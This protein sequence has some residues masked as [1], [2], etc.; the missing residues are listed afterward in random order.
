MH[1][2]TNLPRPVVCHFAHCDSHPRLVSVPDHTSG[3]P[4]GLS[5]WKYTVDI[6]CSRPR[7]NNV[8][9]DV[10]QVRVGQAPLYSQELLLPFG[11]PFHVAL[12]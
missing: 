8:F 9:N 5:F 7:G 3:V 6:A 10:Q 1:A 4:T 2:S 11:R 12:A